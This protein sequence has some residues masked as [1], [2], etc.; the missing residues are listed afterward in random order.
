MINHTGQQRI[1]EG[2]Q[3]KTKN[4]ASTDVLPSH[5]EI[6]VFKAKS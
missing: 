1:M 6:L 2:K 4:Y 3:V 5:P